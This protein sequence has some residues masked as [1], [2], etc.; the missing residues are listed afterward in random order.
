M[1]LPPPESRRLTFGVFTA[2]PSLGRLLKDGTPVKLAPQPFKVLLLLIERRGVMVGRE[3]IREHLWGNSTFVDFERGINFSINQIRAAL[4]D[5]VERPRYIE[6]LPKIGYRFIAEV[7]EQNGHPDSAVVGKTSPIS[8]PPEGIDP[9]PSN[10]E[11]TSGYYIA[12][13]TKPLGVGMQEA[14]THG[15]LSE[16]TTTISEVK[17]RLPATHSRKSFFVVILSILAVMSLIAVA[18]AL[19]L[20]NRARPPQIA[21]YTQL[22]ND[23]RPKNAFTYDISGIVSDGDRVYFQE[24][25]DDRFVV[26]QVHASGGEV[27]SVPTPFANTLVFDISRGRS[28]LLVG[29]LIRGSE[30]SLWALP[31]PAGP[32][33]RLGELSG[34]SATWSRDGKKI[35]FAKNS[36]LYSANGDGSSPRKLAELT[37]TLS[38]IR[39]SPDGLL[40]R[41]TQHDETTDSH[42]LWEIATDGTNLRRV[43]AGWHDPPDECCGTWTRNGEYYVFQTYSHN[44]RK[45]LW[46]LS[47]KSHWPYKKSEEP[48]RLTHGPLDFTSPQPSLD[49]N[50]LF[51]FGL[52]RHSELIRYD[53]RSGFVP[54]MEGLSAAGLAF[55]SDGKWLTYTAVPEGTLWRNKIDGS[56]PLQLTYPPMDVIVPRW[57]PD[58]TW[59]AFSA[60]SSKAPRNSFLIPSKGG[61]PLEIVPGAFTSSDPSWSPD[62]KSIVLWLADSG[63]LNKRI[64]IFDL[65]THIETRLPATEQLFSPRWSPDGRYIAAITADEQKLVVF[66]RSS[67]RWIDLANKWIGYPSWSHDG[68][69]VYFDTLGEDSAFYR[70]RVSDGNLERLIGLKGTRRFWSVWEPWS[71]LAPDDSL[72]LQ[73]DTS[74][75]EVYAL[76]WASD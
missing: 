72:L 1:A 10:A 49:S 60:S 31:I 69:Y 56:E 36:I 64:S 52:K 62:G 43:L 9:T 42:S 76:A 24:I 46:V 75:Q 73:R 59:I 20:V 8:G 13:S 30:I 50:R 28:E 38:W 66:D 48:T 19:L 18:G 63:L 32:A 4:S 61:V 39:C 16:H 2:D 26:G 27:G 17:P 21:D 44:A 5:D 7:T 15:E 47:E 3:E 14:H 12:T 58:G 55:S 34:Q 70:V 40:L 53:S 51:V 29:N 25:K 68:R 22:T 54:Y 23:G 65:T 74:T 57:S 37:G 67:Q 6:T 41:F 35:F 45:D 71:G 11:Q 33:R